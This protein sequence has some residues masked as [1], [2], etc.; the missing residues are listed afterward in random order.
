M[1]STSDITAIES[2]M[3]LTELYK[4]HRQDKIIPLNSQLVS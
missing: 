4:N 2:K 1:R 3:P